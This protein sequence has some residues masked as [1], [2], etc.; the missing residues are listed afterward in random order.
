MTIKNIK[1][2]V[3]IC[4]VIATVT[5]FIIRIFFPSNFKKDWEIEL[6]TYL[7]TSTY[8]SSEQAPVTIPIGTSSAALYIN[9]KY[10]YQ[11]TYPANRYEMFISDPDYPLGVNFVSPGSDI[12]TVSI[13]IHEN[14]EHLSSKQAAINSISSWTLSDEMKQTLIKS[15]I[16][17]QFA[18]QNAVTFTYDRTYIIFDKGYLLFQVTDLD[19]NFQ[20]NHDFLTTFSFY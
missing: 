16:P 5:I 3:I 7:N 1:L 11:I 8:L 9:S 13:W 6:T 10:G 20:K 14:P 17:I 18:D 4:I 15:I 12:P 2:L 19:P